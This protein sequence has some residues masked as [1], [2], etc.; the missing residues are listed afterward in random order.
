MDLLNED[1]LDF[2]FWRRD[3]FVR[4]AAV[5]TKF[6]LVPNVPLLFPPYEGTP[7]SG[8]WFFREMRLLYAF[9]FY[10]IFSGLSSVTGLPESDNN[11]KE[12]I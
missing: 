10:V 7:A 11:F 2:I 9:H 1:F 3:W 12:A 4:A 6:H 8:A 5:T